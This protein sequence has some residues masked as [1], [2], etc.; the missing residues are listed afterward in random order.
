METSFI[1]ATVSSITCHMLFFHADEEYSK[2]QFENNFC[3]DNKSLFNC[4]VY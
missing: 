2:E 3:M 4:H 1:C